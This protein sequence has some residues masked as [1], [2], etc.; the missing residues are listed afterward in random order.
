MAARS[1]GGIGEKVVVAFLLVAVGVLA[2]LHLKVLPAARP[3]EPLPFDL[4]NPMLD[5]QVGECLAME[6]ATH[7]GVLTCVSV[8]EPGVVLRPHLQKQWLPR[9]RDLSRAPPYLAA[10]LLYPP[11]GKACDHPEAKREP[12]VFPLSG[13]G[14]SLTTPCVLESIRPRWVERGPQFRF[15][16]EV[17]LNRYAPHHQGALALMIDP[18]QPVTGVVLRLEPDGKGKVTDVVFTAVDI[19]R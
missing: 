4:E 7:P 6:S 3:M 13:W 12:E 15:V 10:K 5:A 11:T 16:Y 2:W 8:I 1:G 17:H 9:F 19:C 14:L 18:D